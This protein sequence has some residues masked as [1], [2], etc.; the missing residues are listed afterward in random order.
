M[1]KKSITEPNIAAEQE[2]EPMDFLVQFNFSYPSMQ[3]IHLEVNIAN[4]VI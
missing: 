4:I 2:A 3:S 1:T